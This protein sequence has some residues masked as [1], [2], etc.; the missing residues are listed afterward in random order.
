ME[1][2]QGFVFVLFYI[3]I[4]NV[5]EAFSDKVRIEWKS[6]EEGEQTMWMSGRA[7][8][9][10]EQQKGG[11]WAEQNEQVGEWWERGQRGS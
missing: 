3:V 1:S 4:Q 7:F 2:Y 10:R 8:G 9:A 6:V 11:Q 5:K